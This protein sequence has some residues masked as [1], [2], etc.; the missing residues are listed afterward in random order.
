MNLLLA[1]I[2]TLDLSSERAIQADKRIGEL[3]EKNSKLK[4]EA[5]LDVANRAGGYYELAF[6]AF[7]MGEFAAAEDNLRLALEAGTSDS[8]YAE[9]EYLGNIELPKETLD[10][11]QELSD[12]LREASAQ[13]KKFG[14]RLNAIRKAYSEEK[15]E[16]VSD[17]ENWLDEISVFYRL[18]AAMPGLAEF[19]RELAAKLERIR[20]FSLDLETEKVARALDEGNLDGASET[21]EA[22]QA[23]LCRSEE[24]RVG[25]ECRSRWS[26]YH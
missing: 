4:E 6:K 8:T 16:S 9:G 22:L 18:D 21:I 5:I 19:R 12:R 23:L 17:L 15:F 2:G 11:I 3:R 14:L 26:P 25:K 10:R 20:S 1:E 24:R 7:E 13:R